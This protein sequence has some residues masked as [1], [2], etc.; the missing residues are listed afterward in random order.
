MLYNQVNVSE[1][2]NPHHLDSSSKM[3]II[4]LNTKTLL[5]HILIL[6]LTCFIHVVSKNCGCP[7]PQPPPLPQILNLTFLDQRLAIVYPIIQTFKNLITSDPLNITQSWVGSD[8]CSYKG[9]FCD[10]PPDNLSA[11]ALAAIDFNGFQLSAPSLDGFIDQ[12]PDLALFHANSN[13]FSGTISPKIGNLQF[14]YELDLSNNN[15]FGN[16]PIS[17]LSITGLSFLDIRFNSFTGS[18]PPQVFSQSFDMLF[19]NNNNFI[20]KIPENLGSTPALYL[21][22]ANNKF[23]GQIPR[24]IFNTTSTLKEILLLNNFLTGCLPY[25]IGFLKELVLFDASNNLFTGPLPWSFGCLAKMEVLNLAGNLLYGQVPEMLCE[26]GNLANLSL[27]ENYF[28]KL[29]PSCR[30]LVRN[31]VLD[32]RKNCIHDLPDQRSWHECF[33]FFLR[34]KFRCSYNPTFFGFLPCKA[35]SS[36]HVHQLEPKRN[37]ISY[38]ALLRHRL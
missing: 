4:S 34:P 28:S 36:P 3:K 13:N 30:K 22:L 7:S 20:L 17:V 5:I 11:I 14:L 23:T 26:L 12:F 33:A 21:T 37:L 6:F 1:F 9:F 15:F 19:L 10:H 31:G 38:K 29:G 32:V 16:F 25:E 35:H 2:F 18:V 8:I 24:S 27:S